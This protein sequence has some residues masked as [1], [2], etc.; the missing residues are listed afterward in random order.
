MAD[1]DRLRDIAIC[2][3]QCQ[4]P[5]TRASLIKQFR[6]ETKRNPWHRD[7]VKVLAVLKTETD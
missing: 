6:Y 5:V 1:L 4:E 2:M 7:L 3:I